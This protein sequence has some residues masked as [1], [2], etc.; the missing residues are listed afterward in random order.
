MFLFENPSYLV[1]LIYGLS[2][3]ICNISNFAIMCYLSFIARNTNDYLR[4]TYFIDTTGVAELYNLAVFAD[5]LMLILNLI[6]VMKFMAIVRK[7]SVI[8]I[9]IRQTTEYLV[10]LVLIQFLLLYFVAII[11]WNIFGNYLGYFRN[12]TISMLYTFAMFDLKS[13]YLA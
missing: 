9:L 11:N 6:N 5:S 10:Y 2:F 13:M 12:P 7:V 8:I 1:G 3:N 4:V